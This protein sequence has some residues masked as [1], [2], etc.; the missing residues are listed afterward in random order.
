MRMR[1]F[2]K[3]ILVAMVVCMGL[4]DLCGAGSEVKRQ[5]R[6]KKRI[7]KSP[8]NRH[9]KGTRVGSKNRQVKWTHRSKLCKLLLCIG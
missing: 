5:Y 6:A 7:K 4:A 3:A 8:G 1:R 2:N 9:G